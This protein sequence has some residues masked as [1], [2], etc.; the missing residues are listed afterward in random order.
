M[1]ICRPMRLAYADIITDIE[2]LDKEKKPDKDKEKKQ[3]KGQESEPA[4]KSKTPKAHDPGAPPA[5]AARPPP[6]LIPEPMEEVILPPRSAGK[7]S[8]PKGR[9]KTK[10]QRQR[11]PVHLQSNGTSTYSKDRS[12][13]VLQKDVVITQDDMRLESEEAKITLQPSGAAESGVKNALLSGGVSI[14]RYSADPSE[15]MNAKSEKAVFD[16]LAQTVALEGNA[17]LWRDGNLIKGDRIVYEVT[18]GMIKVDK[19]QGVVQPERMKK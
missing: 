17:R 6:A 3:E 4:A 7:A 14:S 5:E 9:A 18:S 10:E 1:L 19:A 2:L 15:R 13:V 12:M 11:A 8:D 16:N